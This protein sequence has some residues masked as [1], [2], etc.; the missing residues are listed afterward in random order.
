MMVL[1]TGSI[2]VSLH[3]TASDFIWRGL[4]LLIIILSKY[5]IF[6]IQS[7]IILNCK[8]YWKELLVKSLVS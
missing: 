6:K 5:H 8:N 7:P 4:Y 3:K 1:L 2:K